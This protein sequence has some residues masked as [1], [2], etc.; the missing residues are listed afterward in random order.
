MAMKHV[1]RDQS[2]MHAATNEPEP[3]LSAQFEFCVTI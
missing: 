2:G 3:Q 1:M